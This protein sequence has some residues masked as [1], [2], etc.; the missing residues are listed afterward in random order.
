MNELPKEFTLNQDAH[1]WLHSINVSFVPG[2]LTPILEEVIEGMRG[3]FIRQ[4]HT[5]Q[6]PP[7]DR[8]EVIITTAP[9]GESLGWRKALIFNVRRLYNLSHTPTFY[10]LVQISAEDFRAQMDHLAA[11][12]QKDEPDPADFNY[13]GLAPDAYKIL[14]GQGRRGGPILALQ[15]LVQAQA[16]SIRVL[17]VVTDDRSLDVY[18]FDLVGANPKSSS[19]DAYD[20]YQDIVMRM[21]TTE[22]TIE[23]KEHQV[24]GETIP[25]E[26]WKNLPTPS[27]MMVAGQ[28]IGERDF[29]TDMIRIADV[30]NVPAVSDT[31]ADQYSEGCF[32]TWEPELDALITTVTGSARPVHKGA[33]TE[34]DLAVIAGVRPDGMGAQVLHVQGKS[35]DPPSTEAVELIDMDNPL[36]RIDLGEEWSSQKQVPVVRSKLHGHRGVKSFD[37]CCVEY[38]PLDPPYYNYPVSCATNAQAQGIKSAFSRAESLNNPDDPRQVAFTVLPGHGT[39]IV[40]KW[41]PG[42]EPFQIIWEYMD[43]GYIEIDNLVPQGEMR[44]V[45]GEGGKMVLEDQ[46]RVG[47]G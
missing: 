10:T 3:E 25:N 33:I 22:S 26:T 30:V 32:A 2:E 44:Y 14:Y 4:G 19:D 21:V 31:I 28:Q 8:T 29:F 40:E 1:T 27:G 12:I 35:N 7:D 42:K 11:A 16:K 5:V 41:V 45:E 39:V 15:R 9:Y 36:P 13:D 37:P 34:D 38:A 43:A 46:E 24:V 17:L 47:M 18:H 6:E 23:V 20:I